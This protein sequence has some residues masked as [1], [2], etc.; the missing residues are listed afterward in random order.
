MD[1]R[2]TRLRTP[3]ECEQFI[4]NVADRFSELV[5]E[6]HRRA[7]ELRAEAHGAKSAVELESLRAVYAYE[8]ALSQ[9]RGKTVRAVRTWQMIKR[10][11]IIKAVEKAVDRRQTTAGYKVLVAMGMKD[12]LFEAVVCRHPE[13]FSPSALKRSQERLKEWNV[14]GTEASD[15]APATG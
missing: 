12:L 11:G 8:K 15:T 1:E 14:G 4:L 13:V 9:T 5:R 3:E 7:V 10:H 2:V 6:A